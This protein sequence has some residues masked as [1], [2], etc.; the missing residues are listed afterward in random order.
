MYMHGIIRRRKG[1]YMPL[2][3]FRYGAIH[4]PDSG[5]SYLV[6]VSARI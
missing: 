1:Q 2:E 3:L 6:Y 5:A 4:S